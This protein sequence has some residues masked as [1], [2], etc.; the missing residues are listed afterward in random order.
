MFQI[1]YFLFQELIV[2]ACSKHAR[3][4]TQ[5]FSLRNIFFDLNFPLLLMYFSKRQLTKTTP[6]PS[7]LRVLYLYGAHSM[8][9]SARLLVVGN[10][11][12]GS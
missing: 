5:T 3:V 2:F 1:L 9:S 11:F 7:S 4:N 6:R 10:K 12:P 8:L